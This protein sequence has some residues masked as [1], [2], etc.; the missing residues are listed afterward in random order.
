MK[1]GF[2]W[3]RFGLLFCNDDVGIFIM[4]GIV[5]VFHFELAQL[6]F[7]LEKILSFNFILANKTENTNVMNFPLLDIFFCSG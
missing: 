6:I 1:N 2:T 7:Y 3:K 5:Y 4:D